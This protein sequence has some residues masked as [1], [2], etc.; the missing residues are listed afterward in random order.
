MKRILY[1]NYD[2]QTQAWEPIPDSLWRSLL[3]DYF[4]IDNDYF[5]FKGL[6]SSEQIH[7]FGILQDWSLEPVGKFR[8]RPYCIPA[9][10]KNVDEYS[11]E[12]LLFAFD[13]LAKA[14][15]S[16]VSLGELYPDNEFIQ[17]EELIFVRGDE[18][19]ASASNIDNHIQFYSLTSAD[20]EQMERYGPAVRR[21]LLEN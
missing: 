5:G 7:N 18:I 2:E 9:T 3:E 16:H 20:L 12:V 10:A 21:G 19:L 11:E 6:A 17:T 13:G 8:Y 14:A 4:R 15:L 1:F